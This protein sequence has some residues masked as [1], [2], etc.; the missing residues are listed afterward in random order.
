[1]SL[2]RADLDERCSGLLDAVTAPARLAAKPDSRCPLAQGSPYA[3]R[4]GADAPRSSAHNHA[5]PKPIRRRGDRAPDSAFG[6]HIE[7]R[8][9]ASFILKDQKPVADRF[10]PDPTYTSDCPR[11]SHAA[12]WELD[13]A[14]F[15]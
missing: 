11:C 7:A 10:E 3:T 13:P 12:I 14:M 9:L 5:P 8:A 1:L 15:K 2:S 4:R 6:A